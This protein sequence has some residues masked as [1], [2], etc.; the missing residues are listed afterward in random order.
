MRRPTHTDPP[1]QSLRGS[2]RQ[3]LLYFAGLRPNELEQ[4][5]WSLEVPRGA[6]IR[7]SAG[8]TAACPPPGLPLSRETKLD[9]PTLQSHG[10]W[11]LVRLR[12]CPS[13]ETTGETERREC[14]RV[15]SDPGGLPC[16]ILLYSITPRTYALRTSTAVSVQNQKRSR[17]RS[18]ESREHGL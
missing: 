7:V 3:R 13:A 12:V 8:A 14:A 2:Q 1:R 15:W 16:F 10:P 18:A 17:H 9:S 11:W 5:A 6:N 4:R